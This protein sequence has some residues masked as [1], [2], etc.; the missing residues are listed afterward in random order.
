MLT[1]RESSA[2]APAPVS[3]PVPVP[4]PVVK[5]SIADVERK[6]IIIQKY[7]NIFKF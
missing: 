5:K 6:E 3:D 1:L 7:I 2:K 4:K